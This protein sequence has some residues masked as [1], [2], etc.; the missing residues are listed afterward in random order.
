MMGWEKFKVLWEPWCQETLAV[1]I[2]RYFTCTRYDSKANL[3]CAGLIVI[4]PI[5]TEKE[6]E[7]RR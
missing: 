3:L 2:R 4:I 7:I 1:I 6:T 5:F